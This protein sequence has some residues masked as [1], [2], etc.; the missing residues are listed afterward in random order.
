M[1]ERLAVETSA[2]EKYQQD[3]LALICKHQTADICITV[4]CTHCE[5]P[6]CDS[7]KDTDS[8]ADKWIFFDD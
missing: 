4:T 1:R 7:E 2:S 3:L 8:V 5:Q 6:L